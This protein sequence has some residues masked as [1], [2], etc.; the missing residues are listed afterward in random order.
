MVCVPAAHA[1]SFVFVMG[2][3]LVTAATASRT[4]VEHVLFFDFASDSV[5]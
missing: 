4:D 2:N 5:S 1:D 3:L